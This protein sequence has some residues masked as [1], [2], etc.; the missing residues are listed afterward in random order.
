MAHLRLVWVL[1]GRGWADCTVSD[2]QAEAEVTASYI[3]T[4]P[5]KIS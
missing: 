3:T 5:P 2:H 1:S 4:A